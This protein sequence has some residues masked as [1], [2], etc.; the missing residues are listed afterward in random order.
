[1][2]NWDAVVED[3]REY[4]KLFDDALSV[5]VAYLKETDWQVIAGIERQREI[6]V[7]V[8]RQRQQAI[9]VVTFA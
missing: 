7:D 1:M 5:S 2:I 3:E 4:D 9:D 8:S 6:P